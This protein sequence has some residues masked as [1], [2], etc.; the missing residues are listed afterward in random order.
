MVLN[1]ASG[2][3]HRAED[4]TKGENMQE[5]SLKELLEAGCHF[6]HQTSRWNPK[7][8]PY[9]YT[10]KG[11]VHIINL[12]LTVS[13]A[14]RA[15]KFLADQVALGN[16][17]LFVGTK[18]QAADLI[19]EQAERVGMF[20]VNQ[21]WL[22]GMLTNFRTI[23]ASID[24]LQTL[25][26]RREA[27]DF[28]KLI[29]KEA[30]G[31]EREIEKLEHSL[32]GIKTMTKIPSAVFIIDPKTEYIAFKE[33]QK[34]KI[35]VIAITDTNSDPDG[36]DFV[37]PANDDAIRSISI[38]TAYFADACAEGAKRRETLIREEV[39]KEAAQEKASGQAAPS[40]RV[41]EKKVTDKARAYVADA[42]PDAKRGPRKG[43]GGTGKGVH[44]KVSHGGAEKKKTEPK[45]EAN[46][47][48]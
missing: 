40:S 42:R 8:K 47:G 45:K 28:A 43:H 12:D 34:L 10:A 48:Q 4:I 17:V 35:P 3:K 36:I 29:K 2:Y 14:V 5:L 19:R 26:Q 27:G 18:R 16:M 37:V 1:K 11:G 9:I 15:Y 33:A 39:A 46:N 24:R 21:R 6:G 13:S 25:Y 31:L 32:G 20:Y 38:L 30:L 44:D 23:K 41:Q 22:G 7:M